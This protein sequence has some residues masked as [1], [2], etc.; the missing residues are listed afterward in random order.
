MNNEEYV[1]SRIGPKSDRGV[2]MT[3]PAV[4]SFVRKWRTRSRHFAGN[5]PFF[6]DFWIVPNWHDL[7]AIQMARFGTKGTLTEVN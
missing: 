2:S 7:M 4:L 6:A 5:L 3:T 1:K